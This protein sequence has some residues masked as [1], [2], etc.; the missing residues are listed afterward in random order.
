MAK[1]AFVGAD[2]IT[3]STSAAAKKQDLVLASDNQ[4][5]SWFVVEPDKKSTESTIDDVVFN[6]TTMANLLTGL[7][8][9][10]TDP[11]DW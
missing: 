9:G 3:V 11:K 4:V 8:N 2:S 5:M 10:E 1:I 6:I 7:N